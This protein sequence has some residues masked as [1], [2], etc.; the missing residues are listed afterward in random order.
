MTNVNVHFS[1]EG[2]TADFNVCGGDYVKWMGYSLNGIVFV[3]SLWGWG[4][5]D[6][7]WLD[8]MTGCQGDCQL[9]GSSVTF[10]NFALHKI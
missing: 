5:Y 1:Q 10:K 8:G 4:G 3:A 7:S 6:V 9:Q 2:R